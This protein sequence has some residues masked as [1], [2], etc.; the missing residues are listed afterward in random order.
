[1]KRRIRLAGFLYC[2]LAAAFAVPGPRG[3]AGAEAGRS[4]FPEERGLDARVS[5]GA[6]GEAL[7][8]I[9]AQLSRA[10]KVQVRAGREAEWEPVSVYAKERPVREVMSGLGELLHYTWTEE[11]STQGGLRATLAPGLRVRRYEQAL[12]LETLDR[13]AAPLFQLTGYTAR[14]PEH[15]RRIQEEYDTAGKQ[16]EDPLLRPG[17]RL[18]LVSLTRPPSRAA[19]ELLTTLSPGQRF[20]LLEGERYLLRWAEMTPR[21]RQLGSVIA[22]D[23]GEVRTRLQPRAGQ[24]AEDWVRWIE[25]FGLVLHV[26]VHPVTGAVTSYSIGEG[27]ALGHVA[28][29]PA[30]PEVELLP[31][32]GSPYERRPDGQVPVYREL[33]GK[34]FPAAFRLE[35]GKRLRWAEIIARLAPLLGMPLFSDDYS[36]APTPSERGG[37]PLPDLSKLSLAEGLNALCDAYRCLWWYHDG[38]LFFRSRTWFIERAYLVPPAVLEGLRKRLQVGSRLQIRD[39]DALARLTPR[40]LIGLNAQAGVEAGALKVSDSRDYGVRMGRREARVAHGYLQV[41]ATL[42]LRRKARVLTPEGLPAAAMSEVQRELFSLLLAVEYGPEMLA[43]PS[44][45]RLRAEQR[46]R[47]EPTRSGERL[48]ADLIFNCKHPAPN[49]GPVAERLSIALPPRR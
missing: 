24:S 20:A 9:L 16:P 7:G 3:A 44:A 5:P 19:L 6:R 47:A 33:E 39:L 14:P 45:L 11:P 32:R 15:Y 2:T 21:Q 27:G 38:A 34:P 1:M 37:K 10:G 23:I 36:A 41:F 28:A 46:V 17:N 30:A 49:E 22:R 40:Q 25:R 42:D 35:A 13:G 18:N 29:L 8:E 31:V 4:L 26:T 43:E 12:W 48:V